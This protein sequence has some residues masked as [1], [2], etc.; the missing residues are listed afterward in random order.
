MIVS[1]TEEKKIECIQ[2][3]TFMTT[4]KH[5][6]DNIET[7]IPML[8]TLLKVFLMFKMRLWYDNGNIEEHVAENIGIRCSNSGKTTG[9]YLKNKDK[10]YKDMVTKFLLNSVLCHVG[11]S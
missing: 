8:P 6:D 1:L 4:M 9:V 2:W 7:W 5:T 10:N 11:L 3:F